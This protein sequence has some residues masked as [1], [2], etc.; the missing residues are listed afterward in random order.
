MKRQILRVGVMLATLGGGILI[1][2]MVRSRPAEQ[3]CA[4]VVEEVRQPLP[5]VVAAPVSTPFPTPSPTP[6]PQIILDYDADRFVPYGVYYVLGKAPK[7][8]ADL[9]CI[10][11]GVSGMVDQPGYITLFARL[12]ENADY[13]Q[14]EATFAIVGER[15]V[16]FATSQDARTGIS[17]RFDGEFLR[18]DLDAVAGKNVA[19]LRGVLTRSRN[20]IK[21]AEKVIDLR[22]EHLGC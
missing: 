9:D 11:L 2:A 12:N 3:K 7:E 1:S 15:K 20:G 4:P 16:F 19:V 8:F 6:S 14:Y 21:T 18:K 17:Y 5:I 10:E 13:T 22:V